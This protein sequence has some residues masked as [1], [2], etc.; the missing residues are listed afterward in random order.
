ML[1]RPK[2]LNIHKYIELFLK[3]TWH[4]WIAKN[5]FKSGAT[6]I[7]ILKVLDNPKNLI[8]IFGHPLKLK[9]NFNFKRIDKS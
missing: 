2:T 4:I 3:F 7:L 8:K 1:T 9:N 6:K 5:I